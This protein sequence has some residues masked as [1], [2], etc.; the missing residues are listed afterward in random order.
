MFHK[1]IF[2]NTVLH[3]LR[4]VQI[5]G[6]LSRKY[7][8]IYKQHRCRKCPDEKTIISLTYSITIYYLLMSAI[9]STASGSPQL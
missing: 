2:S 5:H 4:M 6:L 3:R 9:V 8:N 7:G 1:A